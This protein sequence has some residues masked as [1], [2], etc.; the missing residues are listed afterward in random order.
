[1]D[2]L[3]PWLAVAVL[4]GLMV[5]PALREPPQDGFPVST[6][7][8]FAT[9]RGEVVTID[10]A[11]AITA[12]EEMKRLTPRL[13][14]GADEPILAVRTASDMVAR[15]QAQPWCEEIAERVARQPQHAVVAVEVRTEIHDVM[16]SVLDAA[17]PVAVE[18][19][20]RCPVEG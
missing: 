16:A 8:M 18:V 4:V 5:S 19:H 7:P 1:M 3:V 12:D 13:L 17:E 6:Y 10:T 11:V 2:R 15:G 14:A 9:D 20:A